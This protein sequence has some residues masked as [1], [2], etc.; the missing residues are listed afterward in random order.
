MCFIFSFFL[1]HCISDGVLQSVCK[2][3]YAKTWCFKLPKARHIINVYTQQ[4][5]LKSYLNSTVSSWSLGNFYSSVDLSFFIILGCS[6]LMSCWLWVNDVLMQKTV[7]DTFFCLLILSSREKVVTKS[8]S[9]FW[10]VRSSDAV[11]WLAECQA[12]NSE[13]RPDTRPLYVPTCY[14][15]SH[16]LISIKLASDWFPW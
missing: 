5:P 9:C 12:H 2:I 16:W 14:L 6:L 8:K 7:K 1:S 13:T 4:K 11:F 3:H 15:S 10:L